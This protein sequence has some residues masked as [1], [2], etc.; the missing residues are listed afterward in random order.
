MPPGTNSWLEADQILI[1]KFGEQ[2][3]NGH[4]DV[5]RRTGN[6][7]VPASPAS[8]IVEGGGLRRPTIARDLELGARMIERRHDGQKVNGHVDRAGYRR[9]LRRS[10]SAACV[11]SISDDEQG[12]MTVCAFTD[13]GRGVA[14]RVIER[15]LAP[16][17]ALEADTTYVLQILREP[18]HLSNLRI[19]GK[20]RSLVF[21]AAQV[22]RRHID[23]FASP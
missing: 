18:H 22:H 17:G 5:R 15:G 1:T 12:A 7:H 6:T 8:E 16:G 3:L 13:A 2:I 11:D 21:F 4:G 20:Q 9:D 10:E 19:E 23:G 14:D